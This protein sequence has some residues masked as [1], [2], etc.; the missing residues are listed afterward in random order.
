[1]VGDT[2]YFGSDVTATFYAVDALTGAMRWQFWAGPWSIPTMIGESGT[3]AQGIVWT[4]TYGGR[5]LGLRASD[6]S[7]AVD[8]QL[9]KLG[10]Y[11]GSPVVVDNT[12]I[13]A[14]LTGKVVAFSIPQLLGNQA[15]T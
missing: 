4:A 6:G 15:G 2:V 13:L 5:L 9:P 7:L 8:K 14:S 11:A 12:L 3:L 10:F 1:V